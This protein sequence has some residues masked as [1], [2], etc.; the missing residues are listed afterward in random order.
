MLQEVTDNH[1]QFNLQISEKSISKRIPM[2]LPPL[3]PG[4][5]RI[6]SILGKL[7]VPKN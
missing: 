7:I 4:L 6:E 5:M 3:F 2:I 1:N